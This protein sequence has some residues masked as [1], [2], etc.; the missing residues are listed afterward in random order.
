VTQAGQF[1]DE[2]RNACRGPGNV[3]ID[4]SLVRTF[5]VTERWRLQFRA[6]SFNIMNHANL[7]LPVNDLVSPN[8]G[9]ILEAGPPRLM[10]FALKLLF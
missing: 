7:G 10:Q 6:E 5:T 3:N 4:A 9:R 2:G 1:G 8:F